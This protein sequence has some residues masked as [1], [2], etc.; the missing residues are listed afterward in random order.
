MIGKDRL[1]STLDIRLGFFLLVAAKR[2]EEAIP[3]F[4][5]LDLE[6]RLV[7]FWHLQVLGVDLTLRKLF[8]APVSHA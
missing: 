4:Y 2:G 7:P 1:L 6:P 5:L 3:P 8:V